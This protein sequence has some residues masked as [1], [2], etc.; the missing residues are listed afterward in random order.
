MNQG[1]NQWMLGLSIF[2]ALLLALLIVL[3]AFPQ[4]RASVTISSGDYSAASASVSSSKDYIYV[5]DN[6]TRRL[7]V[8]RYDR[9]G[10]KIDVVDTRDLGKDLK[11]R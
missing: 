10:K 4:A 3:N 2:A 1:K 6:P 7:I 9:N 5:V 11:P 8:Y